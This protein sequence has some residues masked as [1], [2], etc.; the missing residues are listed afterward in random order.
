MKKNF[1]SRRMFG[2]SL[3]LAIIIW[4]VF[5]IKND[6]FAVIMGEKKCVVSDILR[7]ENAFYTVTPSPYSCS[8]LEIEYD[9]INPVSVKKGM[10][11]Y[12][13]DKEYM[14]NFKKSDN[15]SLSLEALTKLDKDFLKRLKVLNFRECTLSD[16]DFKYIEQLTHVRTILLNKSNIPYDAWKHVGKLNHLDA[17]ELSNTDVNDY[18]LFE[19]LDDLHNLKHVS[20]YFADYVTTRGIKNILQEKL[21]TL[22]LSFT[23]VSDEGLKIIGERCPNLKELRLSSTVITNDG[24]K[25]IP[26]L[27]HLRKLNLSSTKIDNGA[28]QYFLKLEN[29]THLNLDGTN[30]TLN[31]IKELRKCKKLQVIDIPDQCR[32]KNFDFE[33]ILPGVEIH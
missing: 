33:F 22:N 28:I 15:V 1:S 9:K 14:Y 8:P 31:G 20:L 23:G 2:W 4:T 17:I 24:I 19:H 30:V 10:I 18:H 29:L 13:S 6:T 26:K 16:V 11:K 3:F 5:A 21:I 12:S 32:S 7:M 25:A 27:S